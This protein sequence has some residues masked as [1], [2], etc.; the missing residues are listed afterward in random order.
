MAT[1]VDKIEA[2]AAQIVVI[3]NTTPDHA[4]A[5]RLVLAYFRLVHHAEK[6]HA[7][8]LLDAVRGY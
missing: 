8:R 6:L 7:Q 4:K 2:R 1:L 5:N 3:I